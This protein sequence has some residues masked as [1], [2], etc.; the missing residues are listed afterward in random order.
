MPKFPVS[1]IALVAALVVLGARWTLIERVGSPV[2]FLDQWYAEGEDLYLASARGGVPAGHFFQAHNDHRIIPTRALAY[3]LFKWNDQWDVRLQMAINA[4][5][6]A[7]LCFPL[8]ALCRPWMPALGLLIAGALLAWFYSLPVLYENALWGFQSQFYFLVLFSLVHLELT[9]GR[10]AFSFAWWIGMLAGLLAL[11]SMGS[12]LLAPLAALVISGW[13]MWREPTSRRGIAPTLFGAAALVAIGAVMLPP[14]LAGAVEFSL[15]SFLFTIGSAVS[16]PQRGISPAGLLVWLPFVIFVITKFRRRETSASEW[17]LLAVGAWVLL[18]IGAIGYAR[19]ETG[20]ILA[21]RY[22]E[23]LAVGLVVNLVAGIWLW[24]N[25]A[26][27]PSGRWQ[28]I[29][30]LVFSA[31]W[32]AFVGHHAIEDARIF[33]RELE[34]MMARLRDEQSDRIRGFYRRGEVAGIAGGVYPHI[35]VVDAPSLV[36]DLGFPELADTMPFELRTPIPL[37]FP[38]TSLNNAVPV[39]L[40]NEPGALHRGTFLANAGNAGVSNATSAPSHKHSRRRLMFKVAGD[41]KRGETELRIH[42]ASGGVA[43][44]ITDLKSD[45]LR[46]VVVVVPGDT[47]QVEVF[48]QSSTRWIAFLDPVEI[49]PL[50]QTAREILPYGPRLIQLGWIAFGLLGIWSIADRRL[51]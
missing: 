21:N 18:Q 34:P 46:P 23:I 24:R 51:S 22:G 2:P 30:L 49:G 28:R 41:F 39:S 7:A 14:K 20:P 26:P 6:A 45:T 4:L 48:D 19:P 33:Q 13:R 43:A 11:G 12:G 35:P 9:L 47:F 44:V 40:P 5:L 17:V 50:S 31:G 16:F 29:A 32:F 37:S 42:D 27:A 36:R 15:Q 3:G 38:D 10:S 8:L 1:L 25:I